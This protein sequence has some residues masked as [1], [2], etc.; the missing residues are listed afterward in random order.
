M[1]VHYFFTY[2]DV[3]AANYVVNLV[4]IM[5]FVDFCNL[6]MKKAKEPAKVDNKI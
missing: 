5:S 6:T 1:Y 4:K 2:H 3:T